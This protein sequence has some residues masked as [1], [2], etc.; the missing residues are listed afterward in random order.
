MVQQDFTYPG[1]DT[2]SNHNPLAIKIQLKFKRMK[3][4]DQKLNI[5][6]NKLQLL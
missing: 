3:K 2:E 4:L 1:M 5:D 6:I